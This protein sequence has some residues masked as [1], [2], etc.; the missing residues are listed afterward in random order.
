MAKIELEIGYNKSTNRETR[1]LGVG[2][3]LYYESKEMEQYKGYTISE[4]Y[5]LT[6]TVT[7]T[8]GETIKTGEVVGDVSETDMRHIQI[9]ETIKSH[10]EKEESLFNQGIKSLS[11][12]FTDEVSK[13]CQYDED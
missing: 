11:L 10:F 3:N 8:N 13:Y 2:D 4:I 6:G 7:F 1:N 9:R 5:P 12:F